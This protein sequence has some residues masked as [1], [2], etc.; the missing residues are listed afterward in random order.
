MFYKC[1]VLWLSFLAVFFWP[2]AG[3]SEVITGTPKKRAV[4]IIDQLEMSARSIYTGCIGY[5]DNDTAD[6]NIAIR[7]MLKKDGRYYIH[8]G[9][10]IVADSELEAEYNELL[11]KA[12]NLFKSLGYIHE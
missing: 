5:I 2:M 12:K 7:T 6:F 8:A 4:E 10:G 9:G 1:N 11:L 3:F